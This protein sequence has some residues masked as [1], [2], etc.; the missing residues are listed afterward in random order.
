MRVRV[1][2]RRAST[3]NMAVARVGVERDVGDES[4]FWHGRLDRTAG[5]ADEVLVVQGLRPLGIA[6]VGIGIR[7]DRD[8]RDAQR[9]RVLG[10]ADRLVDG[11]AHHA[12]HEQ[13][14]AMGS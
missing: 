13:F 5:A 3:H 12:G 14:G 8:R 4:Q 1:A 7:K 9:D 6:E 2:A 11:I 10:G